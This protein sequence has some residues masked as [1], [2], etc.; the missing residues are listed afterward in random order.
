MI[1]CQ[2]PEA[3]QGRSKENQLAVHVDTRT[4]TLQMHVTLRCMTKSLGLINN[5][6]KRTMWA[7]FVTKT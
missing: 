7:E 2:L 6:N 1:R 3:P 4:G 5:I